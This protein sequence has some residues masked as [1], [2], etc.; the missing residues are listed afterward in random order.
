MHKFQDFYF[1]ANCLLT[2]VKISAILEGCGIRPAALVRGP[3]II[4]HFRVLVNRQFSQILNKKNLC[5]ICTKRRSVFSNSAQIKNAEIFGIFTKLFSGCGKHN[6][7]FFIVV[8]EKNFSFF[9]CHFYIF[10]ICF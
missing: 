8:S 3:A 10:G 4:P 6:F 2:I 5:A 9:V 7:I 1:C